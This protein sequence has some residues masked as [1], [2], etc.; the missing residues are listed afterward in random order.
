M[1]E[2]GRGRDDPA[3]GRDPP[4]PVDFDDNGD[5]KPA[6]VTGPTSTAKYGATMTMPVV[7]A[8]AGQDTVTLDIPGGKYHGNPLLAARLT[9][10]PVMAA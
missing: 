5:G 4:L 6:M 8:D 3:R 1:V 7:W 2:R 10:I 9:D